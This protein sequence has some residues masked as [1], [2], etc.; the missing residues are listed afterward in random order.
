MFWI[1]K[2]AM[3]MNIAVNLLRKQVNTAAN[4][5]KMFLKHE[6]QRERSLI[7]PFQIKAWFLCS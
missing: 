4:Q 5:K 3:E 2:N 6:G 7:S 1:K